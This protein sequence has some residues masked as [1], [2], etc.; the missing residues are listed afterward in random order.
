MSPCTLLGLTAVD[1]GPPLFGAREDKFRE[2][3]RRSPAGA[4]PG[5]TSGFR[6]L[7][8]CVQ[9]SDM[10]S[11]LTQVPSA[12]SSQGPGTAL[13]FQLGHPL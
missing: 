9:G 11:V 6:L 13:S 2:C 4:F 10:P 8:A 7:G 1:H 3:T 12:D 5:M